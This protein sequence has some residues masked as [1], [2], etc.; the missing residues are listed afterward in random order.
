MILAPLVGGDALLGV[1]KI[2]FSEPHMAGDYEKELVQSFQPH[3]VVALRNFRRFDRLRRELDAAREF[4][5]GLLPSRETRAGPAAIAYRYRPC[6][7]L[8]GDFFDVVQRDDGRVALLLT[9]VVMPQ[10]SGQELSQRVSNLRGETKTLYMSGYTAEAIAHHGVLGSETAFL[11]KPVS[12]KRVA[13]KVRE[14]L[15]RESPAARE[16]RE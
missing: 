13:S 15:G 5:Q 4:Q 2:A 9:D 6:E 12:P 1:L 16:P 8:G 10:M 14:I 7:Q 11:E 3:I